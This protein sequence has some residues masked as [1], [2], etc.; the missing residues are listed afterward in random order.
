MNKKNARTMAVAIAA[1]AMMIC[2]SALAAPG[3]RGGGWTGRGP[4]QEH[5]RENRGWGDYGRHD[6]DEH[7]DR[8]NRYGRHDHYDRHDRHDRYDRHDRRER[9]GWLHEVVKQKQIEIITAAKCAN[10]I[11]VTA[12]KTTAKIAKAR[13]TR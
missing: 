9:S 11:G 13:H 6:R 10:K 5:C 12:A 7:Y 8:N 4:A 1:A 2:G 3:V